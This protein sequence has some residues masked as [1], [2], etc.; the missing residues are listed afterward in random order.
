MAGASHPERFAPIGPDDDGAGHDGL[1]LGV[2]K[3]GAP[4]CEFDFAAVRAA[5]VIVVI[6]WIEITLQLD[7]GRSSRNFQRR[8]S[9]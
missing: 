9:L 5:E 3:S 7:N 1:L 6:H 2:S 4:H 8:P